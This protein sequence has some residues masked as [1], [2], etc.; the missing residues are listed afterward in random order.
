MIYDKIENIER[1]PFLNKIKDFDF[2]MAKDGKF[3]IDGDA[4]FGIGLKY[5]TKNEMDC[6]WESHKKYLD[7]HVILEGEE[8]VNISDSSQMNVTKEYDD[9]GDY[10]LH[11]G[12]KQQSIHLK[13]GSF[14]VLYPNEVHQTAIYVDKINSISKVVFKILI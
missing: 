2:K 14:L 1:Y 9:T 11:S 10:M 6:L 8:I 12:I 3:E 7:V 4:F 13:K 5:D